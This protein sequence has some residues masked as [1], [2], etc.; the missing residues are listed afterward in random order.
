[1]SLFRDSLKMTLS[2]L[3]SNFLLGLLDFKDISRDDILTYSFTEPLVVTLVIYFFNSIF[4][5]I[6]GSNFKFD[7]SEILQNHIYNMILM[8]SLYQIADLEFIED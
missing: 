1:M 7:L 5:V 2:I 8:L 4:N 6:T 3:V